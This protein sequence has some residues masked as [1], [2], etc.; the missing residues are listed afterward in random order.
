MRYKRHKTIIKQFLF[1]LQRLLLAS[2]FSTQYVRDAHNAALERHRTQMS[3]PQDLSQQ[4]SPTLIK[5]I[6]VERSPFEAPAVKL[7]VVA[8]PIKRL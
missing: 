5:L 8:C 2:I 4:S 1:L 3:M 7:A 6:K